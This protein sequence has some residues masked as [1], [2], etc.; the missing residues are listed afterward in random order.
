MSEAVIT[1]I[2]TG[3]CVALPSVLATITSNRS[4]HK[5]IAYRIDKLEEKVNT[6]NNLISRTYEL[7]KKVEILET[8]MEGK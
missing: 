7:E 1:S 4:N 5:L 2:I 6:H 3:L 8:K